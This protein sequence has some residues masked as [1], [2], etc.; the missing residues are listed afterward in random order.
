MA[1]TPEGVIKEQI[2]KTL[3]K[4]GDSVY[5]FMPVQ[6]G[7]G[8]ATIDYLVCADGLFVGIEAKRPGA[9][10]TPRQE[11]VLSDIRRAGGTT[12]VIDDEEDV[13]ALD[14][15]LERMMRKAA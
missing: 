11:N 4:Y 8:A 14:I 6:Y 12:F 15:F 5:K 2:K 10:P 13:K 3:D 9:K 7:Y 1:R